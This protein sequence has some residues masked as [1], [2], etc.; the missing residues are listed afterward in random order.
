MN[1]VL[2]SDFQTRLLSALAMVPVPVFLAWLGGYW[3]AALMCV[4]SALLYW[5]WTV[6]T[7]RSI[8]IHRDALAGICILLLI[9]SMVLRP[10]TTPI[11]ISFFLIL[12]GWLV[13]K[14]WQLPSG[15][16]IAGIGVAS[17]LSL[18]VIYIRLLDES[19]HNG[20]GLLVFLCFTIFS[21]DSFAYLVGRTVGGPKL[22]PSVSP[23]KTWAGFFGGFLGAAWMSALIVYLFSL[24]SFTSF[25]MIALGLAFAAQVGDLVESSI[26]R[27][28]N[29]KDVS[30]LIPGHGG[31][32]DRVDG[33]I[34]AAYAFVA[35]YAI[36]LLT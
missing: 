26:K 1:V 29:K 10:A 12:M 28:F 23:K 4:V 7:K 5:E 19:G 13:V 32:L 17:G 35:F 15:W 20:L 2:T 24:G 31:L 25:I 9:L 34:L 11:L 16:T 27:H 6:L 33:L 36:G 30:N 18:C 8:H 14:F 3:F 22:I 21:A